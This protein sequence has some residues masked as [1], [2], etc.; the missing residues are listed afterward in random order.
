MISLSVVI[1]TMVAIIGA[2]WM[3]IKFNKGEELTKVHRDKYD[4]HQH[5]KRKVS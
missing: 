5:T 3:I 4:G 2:L 1:I